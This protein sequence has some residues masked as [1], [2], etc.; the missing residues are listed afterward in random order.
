LRRL[1]TT[2]RTFSPSVCYG[3]L[4][5][6][7]STKERKGVP[8][9]RLRLTRH[10]SSDTVRF[11]RYVRERAVTGTSLAARRAGRVKGFASRGSKFAI[12]SRICSTNLFEQLPQILKHFFFFR[13][14][15]SAAD[16]RLIIFRGD[17][18]N[19]RTRLR[20]RVEP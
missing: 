17:Q 6:E 13:A 20:H 2:I 14:A 8:R 7:A 5:S 15:R 11:N 12:R 16:R 18:S 10:Y 3:T 9:K 4:T 1:L 19:E